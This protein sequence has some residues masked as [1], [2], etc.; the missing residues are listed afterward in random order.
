MWEDYLDNVEQVVADSLLTVQTNTET[1]S[2]TLSAK[3]DEYG[4]HVSSAIVTPWET[5]SLA[6]SGY[7]DSFD[8]AM[9]STMDQLNQLEVKWQSIIALMDL[10][11]AKEI[12]AQNTTK[13]QTESATYQPPAT[14]NNGASSGASSNNATQPETAKSITVGG[15]INAGSAKIYSD[16]YGSGASSQYYSKD[17]VYVVLQE[18]NGYLLV[19]HHS[20]S[21]GYTGWFKKSDVKAYAKGSLGVDEDQLALLHELGDELV[22]HAGENG[23]LE[24]LTKGTG[25]V[26]ADLTE[27]LMDLAMNPQEVLDR[28]RPEIGANSSVIN[29][30]MEINMQIA[31]VV[32]IDRADNNSVPDITNAVKKQ[33]DSYMNQLNNAIKAKVR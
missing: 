31:E 3:A 8:T 14:T 32:H 24:F 10:Y 4:L 16:A 7:Q 13:E 20:K 25:V 9:S 2:D 5:G 33:L 6:I 27:R 1:V 29:N 21:S 17:P 23:K 22:L 19:R 28:N 11:A 12:A 30:T 15:K 18:K 26:P